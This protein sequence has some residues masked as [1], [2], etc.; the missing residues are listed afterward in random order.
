MST[1]TEFHGS[2]CELPDAEKSRM[3]AL[4]YL[5]EGGEYE[6][7]NLLG[8]CALEFGSVK[9]VVDHK[10]AIDV[11]LRCC[12]EQLRRLQP[13]TDDG[14]EPL[15]RR[16]IRAAIRDTLPGGFCIATFE[17][18][19]GLKVAA[20]VV[21]VPGPATGGKPIVEGR[22]ELGR[23]SYLPGFTRVWVDGE[24]YDLRQRKKVRLCLQYLMEKRAFGPGSARHFLEEINPYVMTEG[25]YTH[26]A[27]PKIDHYFNDKAGRLRKLRKA[28]IHAEGG[29][30][31]YYLK[32]D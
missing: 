10:Y 28:L 14:D 3:M 6:E 7:A 21:S 23:M 4:G 20:P 25:D 26:P 8:S 30:G 2:H 18:R 24:E 13:A 17:P 12:R 1:I 11:T 29:T 27:A 19:A 32:V 16:R 22:L 15:T 31:R 9:F 5:Q